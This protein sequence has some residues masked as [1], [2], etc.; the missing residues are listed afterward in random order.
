MLRRL[1]ITCLGAAALLMA[2]STDAAESPLLLGAVYNLSGPQA[3]FDRPASRGA[4]LAVAQANGQ[5]GVLGRQVRLLIADP[6][7]SLGKVAPRVRQLLNAHPQVSA[8]L[9]LSDTDMVLAAAP[10]AAARKLVFVTSGATSPKLP[11]EVPDFLFLACFGDNVQ[12]AAA[13]EYAYNELGART[14]SI[15]YNAAVTYT[16]LLQGYFR[17]R[18]EALG[19]KV[20][21]VASY[22]STADQ[23]EALG[24]LAGADAIFLSAQDPPEA[25][26]GAIKLRAAGID[27]P[28]LGGDG[29]DSEREWSKHPALTKIYFTTHA[30]LGPDNPDPMVKAFDQAYRQAYGGRAPDSFAALGYDAVGV[31]LAAVEAAGSAEPARVLDSLSQL[32]GYKG[33]TGTISYEGGSRIPRKS[34]T[35]LE[36]SGGKTVFVEQLMPEQVPPP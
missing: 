22:R 11:A 21:S 3:A 23:D 2:P 20:S 4:E 5:G 36:V 27:V 29:F 31:L 7:G 35:I 28:I 25:A 8:M 10:V 6:A 9:G 34:V 19:G 24:S 13:A 14:V 16:A 32:T 1:A 15:L 33:V 17:A 30:Y 18:F 26:A 12:A